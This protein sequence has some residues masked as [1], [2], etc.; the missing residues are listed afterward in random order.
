MNDDKFINTGDNIRLS[1]QRILIVVILLSLLFL[2]PIIIFIHSRINSATIDL[3]VAPESSSI[4]IDS[5]KVTNGKIGVIPGKHTVTAKKDGFAEQTLTI[6]TIANQTVSAYIV[7]E[8]NSKSTENWYKTH[9]EDQKIV[10]QISSQ[11][12]DKE[13]SSYVDDNPIIKYLPYETANYTLNYGNCESSTFCIF[14]TTNPADYDKIVKIIKELTDDPARYSYV[15][16]NYKNPFQDLKTSSETPAKI[17]ASDETTAKNF[18]AETLKNYPVFIN[19]LSMVD[20][21]FIGTFSYRISDY[22]DINT[23]RFILQKDTAGGWSFAS[24]PQMIP[25]YA[26]NQNLPKEV[27]KKVNEL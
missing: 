20:N 26:E 19:P 3:L 7:L 6:D 12:Y 21:Y 11:E 13:S 1:K 27:V 14:I 25:T 17:S 5:N 8:S 16:N 15:F 24:T 22:P 9:P 23:Y 4:Y 10:E 2:I 18:L